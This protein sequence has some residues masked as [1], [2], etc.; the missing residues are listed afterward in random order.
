MDLARN[1]FLVTVLGV[2]MNIENDKEAMTNIYNFVQKYGALRIK[3]NS[4]V[5][6][7]INILK[8][9]EP[10]PKESD[11]FTFD[12]TFYRSIGRITG[13]YSDRDIIHLGN[14]SVEI[15]HVPGHADGMCC[16]Y[17]PNQSLCYVSDYNVYTNWGPWYGGEDS[18]IKDLLNSVD[19]IRN[20]KADF[21][22][23]AH[24][25]VLIGKADFFRQL[26]IFLSIIEKRNELIL[27]LLREGLN[28]EEISNIGIFYKKKYFS[29]P[30]I[31]VWE[32]MMMVKHFEYLD[33]QNEIPFE[34]RSSF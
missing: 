15:I 26:D 1:T 8:G 10:V 11:S 4:W 29:H 18:G 7:L 9:T 14:E 12:E 3:G 19:N 33:L 2:K 25:P 27:K 34:Y 23:T 22:L 17:F 20:V 13:T 28:F 32:K 31:Q 21:F 24:D 16:F 5:K 30:W 6:K